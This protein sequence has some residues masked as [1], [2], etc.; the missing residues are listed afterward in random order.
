M[1]WIQKEFDNIYE[2]VIV[3][4]DPD[5]IILR[6]FLFHIESESKKFAEWQHTST[7]DKNSNNGK[8]RDLY[9]REGHPVSQKYGIGA[10]WIRW[11]GFCDDKKSCHPDDRYAWKYYSV[12]PPYIM[13]KN[14]WLKITPK[15]VDYSPLALEYEPQP[16]ILAEMYSYVLAC[17]YFDLPHQYLFSMFS[18][19]TSNGGMENVDNLNWQ[20]LENGKDANS[21]YHEFHII[22]FC[23][24]Y[25]LGQ[26]RN[27][28]TIRN[29]GYNWHKGHVPLEMMYNCEIPLLTELSDSDDELIQMYKNR[30]SQRDK[31][32]YWILYHLYKY[33]NQAVLNYR[34]KYCPNDINNLKYKLV[35]E[36]P[37]ADKETHRRM[38]YVLGEFDSK[39][40]WRGH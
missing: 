38:N 32:H 36:Q 21:N 27:Q 18:D 10:K 22:H 30:D 2:N 24:G 3:L 29:G 14:D 28:G 9:V 12:G 11:K 8:I 16:S 37:E 39:K 34:L 35:L 6:P 5:M 17:A 20:F 26:T 15:W 25:W 19:P 40:S 7:T 13:H 31:R 4:L 23:Q 33:V 1:T